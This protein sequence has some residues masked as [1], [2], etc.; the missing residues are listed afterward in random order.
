[1]STGSLS[2]VQLTEAY[3]DRIKAGRPEK[4]T[5]SCSSTRPPLAQAH[6]QWTCGRR[7]GA[8]PLG[9]LD[10]IPVLLKGQHRHE[11][12]ADNGGLPAPLLAANPKQDAPLVNNPAGRAGAIILGKTKPVRNGPTFRSTISTSGW[13]R[14][15]GAQTNNPYVPEPESV[16]F[17]VR[18]RPPRVAAVASPRVGRSGNRKRT[19]RSVCPSGRERPRRPS[20]RRSA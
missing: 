4:S 20:S 16:R 18:F 11:E 5:L 1:M 9:L 6:A 7:A 8:P 19:A 13:F 3:L 2:A 10:G 17:V 12:P 15:F 14:P